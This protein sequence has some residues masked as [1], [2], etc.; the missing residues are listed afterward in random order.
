MREAG[1]ART[2]KSVSGGS[3][4]AFGGPHPPPTPAHHRPN[5]TGR[6]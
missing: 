2:F 1:P 5:R 4:P 6:V 3:G